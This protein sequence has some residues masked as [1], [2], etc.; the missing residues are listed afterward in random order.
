[1]SIAGHGGVLEVESSP[2]FRP[3]CQ[4]RRRSRLI[5]FRRCQ[6][7][8]QYWSQFAQAIHSLYCWE[9]RAFL[10]WC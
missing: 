8:H 2:H 6:C 9:F 10:R 3:Y 4:S 7:P 5:Q 1:M